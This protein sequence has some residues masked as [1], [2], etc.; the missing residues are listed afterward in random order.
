LLDL[1]LV[2]ADHADALINLPAEGDAPPA[3]P[4][5]DQGQRVVD[6]AQQAVAA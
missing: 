6:G 4:L 2:A 5:A 1:A 3:G